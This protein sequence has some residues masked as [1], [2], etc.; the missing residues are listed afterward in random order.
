MGTLPVSGGDYTHRRSRIGA[1]ELDTSARWARTWTG[2]WMPDNLTRD[3]L[4]DEAPSSSDALQM[5]F[6]DANV[7]LYTVGLLPDAA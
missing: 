6:V 7:L 3:E 4:D 1:V 2:L 5:R